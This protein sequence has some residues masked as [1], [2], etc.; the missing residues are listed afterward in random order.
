[1]FGDS[2]FVILLFCTGLRFPHTSLDVWEARPCGNSQETVYR[3]LKKKKRLRN[4]NDV[5]C[6]LLFDTL[7][8]SAGSSFSMF[9][10]FDHQSSISLRFPHTRSLAKKKKIERHCSI[11]FPTQEVGKTFDYVSCF[12]CAVFVLYPLPACF[13][14]EQIIV[15]ASLFVNYIA[16]VSLL[17]FPAMNC[18]QSS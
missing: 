14:T 11:F 6:Y 18:W 2:L 3:S 1:M 13:T 15:G 17:S 16:I 7:F 4:K 10:V 9:L 12:P 8:F 5:V